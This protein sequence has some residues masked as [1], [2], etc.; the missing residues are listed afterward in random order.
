[1]KKPYKVVHSVEDLGQI[2]NEIDQADAIG[3]D[4]ET[5][6][7]S[8]VDGEIRICS[9]NTRKG[10]YVIDLFSTKTLGPV[11]TALNDSNTIKIL[12]GAS[13][14]QKWLLRK[15]GIELWPVFDTHRASELLHNGKRL[16]QDL[17]ALYRRE[18]DIGPEV[19]DKGGSDWSNPNLTPEQYDYAAEDVFWLHDL[20]DKLKAK[21][22][23][24]GLFKVALIEF[25]AVLP[26]A[27]VELNG[28]FLDREMWLA[29]AED[30]K[31]EADRLE[32]ELVFELPDPSNQVSLPGF[33]PKFNLGSPQQMLA[34]IRKIPGIKKDLKDTKQ[35]TLAMHAARFPLLNKVLKYRTVSKNFTSFGP[36]YVEHIHAKTGRVHAHY[37][38][39]LTT[40]RYAC[41]KPNL[42]QIPRDARFRACF[43]AAPGKVLVAA[44]YGQVEV[45]L[46]CEISGD[47]RLHQVF[48]DKIDIHTYTAAIA[49]GIP[50]EKVTK[51]QRQAAK[52][53]NFGL[54]Y[55]MQPPKL[56]IYAQSS[57]GVAMS[58]RDAKR[59]HERYFEAYSGVASWH[60]RV[61]TRGKQEK[62]S[63]SMGG[64]LRWLH[65]EKAHN[66]FMNTPVQATGADGLKAALREVYFKLKPYGERVKMVHHVHD[67][68]ILEVDD[69]LDL[70]QQAKLDL[71]A[72]MRAGMGQFLK[73]VPVEVDA[74]HGSSWAACK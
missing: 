50:V 5:T 9:V 68:I 69:D 63:R 67:E 57:Y 18:L 52:A 36:K 64:R 40:G 37:W 66:E 70:I 71:C 41:S 7:L 65:D 1:V 10:I 74:A 45:R 46:A 55:G 54:I 8:P 56:V 44:D 42:A 15:Y 39:F 4:L 22:G 60:E 12:Q 73:T 43:R 17:Y 51:A 19:D 49:M 21:L 53:I 23:R 32:R 3:L 13:F 58:L 34:S 30:N 28:F 26:E 11:G 35:Q 29:L 38:P 2:A 24:A 61:L 31:K 27:S 59:F 47:R 14:D 20:R 16:P 48:A 62:I 33:A 72:G 6:A 25:G